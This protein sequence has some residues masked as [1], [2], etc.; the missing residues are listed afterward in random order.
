M[1]IQPGAQW[2]IGRWRVDGDADEIVAEGRVVK[3]EPQQMKL[4][5]MLARRAGQVVLTQELLDE[6][7][8][9][10]V[11]TPNSVYQAVA[12][13]R[14]QL[15][16]TAA[17]PTYIQTVH[18]KGYRL[19]A[20]VSPPV[21]TP[22]PA[23]VTVATQEPPPRAAA[24]FAAPV[25]TVAA[26]PTALPG[27]NPAPPAPGPPRRRWLQRLGLGAAAAT[28]VAIAGWRLTRPA[29]PQAVPRLA[30]LPFR[31]RHGAEQAL[32]Q[33]LALDVI[34]ALGRHAD[35]AVLAADSV[36][37][38]PAD[39][40]AQPAG[41]AQ[42]LGVRHLLLGSLQRQGSL[43]Q[44]DLRLLDAAA[45]PPAEH[46][47]RRFE[48]S[49]AVVSQLPLAVAAEVAA[50]LGLPPLAGE[51]AQPGP[52][53]A[54]ELYVLGENAWRPR[55]PEA[56]ERAR[57]YFQRGVDADPGFARNYVGLAWTWMGQATTGAGLDLPP[58]IARATPLFE[59]ALALEP[60]AA[61]AITGQA[62]LHEFAGELDVA[63]RLLARA[64]ELQPNYAQAH[65]SWGIVEFQDG[66]PLKAIDH[67]ERAAALNP[68]SP[69]VVERLGIAQLLA[70][71]HEAAAQAFRRTIALDPRYP[72][73]AW[74]LGMLGYATGELVQAVAGYRQA[75]ALEPRR[76]YLWH[77][78]GW[79]YLDL[80]RP[81]DAAA[82][83]AQA[84]QHLPATDWLPVHAAY[85]WAARSD[86]A[87]RGE[88]P[89]ALAL[90]TQAADRGAV[91]TDLCF[92]RALAGLPLD[93]GLLQRSQDVANARG[94]QTEAPDAWFVFQ[95]WHRPL[96]LA[97][98]QHQL[99]QTQA[100]AATL[101]AVERQL[102]ALAAQGN[103][104][105]MLDFHRARLLALRGR[106]AEVPAALERAVGAGL[107]R[108]WW[109]RLDPALAPLRSDARLQRLLADIDARTA[110]QRR[111]LGL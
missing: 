8:R 94:Q 43:L 53:E 14:R 64:V 25:P 77:E 61:D 67:F 33:G 73:G 52:S 7:W 27:P 69:A 104:W 32:A 36:L 19:V 100:A 72:N 21:T 102:D 48:R 4:L 86:P 88:P 2:T 79:L 18:R 45:A 76:P 68:L 101:D 37:A 26:A 46:W 51:R 108:G 80:Q 28:A 96:N 57:I 65:M 97:T 11:V 95:G 74:G 71:R 13:L 39:A 56:F 90:T 41:L 63:R 99:G 87:A 5:L 59:R 20:P 29:A 103:R 66:R 9:D 85:A 34:R 92:V 55:T 10:L 89:S 6:V 23:P 78:L 17:E 42:R 98:V 24:P 47:R 70:G 40:E 111:Q 49:P 54:Y 35:L 60:D 91:F 12:Q 105:P 38:V 1:D 15:G 50:A 22:A 30:V 44:L 107:R 3:L 16:D 83:F 110:Q 31:D 109:L 106:P 82:A 62:L 93:A 84:L 58:A 81:D 75:L